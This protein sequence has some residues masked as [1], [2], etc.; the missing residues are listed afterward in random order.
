VNV[1]PFFSFTFLVV[2]GLNAISTSH[3]PL[4]AIEPSQVSRVWT[5]GGET[6]MSVI[7]IAVVLDL[8]VSVMVCGAL[9]RP[10]MTFLKLI[11]FRG[12]RTSLGALA[13]ACVSSADCAIT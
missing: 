4:A 7:V 5:N 11:A 1:R 12:E 13:L 8:L 6:L 3:L 2:V 10:T 9:V